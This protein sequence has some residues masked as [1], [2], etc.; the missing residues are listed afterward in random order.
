MLKPIPAPVYEIL[1]TFNVRGEH[2]DDRQ[3]TA[4]KQVLGE[5]PFLWIWSK[6]IYGQIE[7]IDTTGAFFKSED[8]KTYTHIMNGKEYTRV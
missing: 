7:Y 1:E 3:I 8:S 5:K 6:P 2:G 4:Q